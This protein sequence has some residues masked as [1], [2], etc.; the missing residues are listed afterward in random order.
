MS[1]SIIAAIGKNNE[2]GKEN[3][4]L[5]DLPLD[6]KHFKEIT[7]GKTIIMGQKTFES[8]GRP[9]PNRRNIVLTRD[10]NLKI[11]GVEIVYSM[12][13]AFAL[14]GE[15]ETES[16]VIGGGQIYRLFFGKASKLYLTHVE[17][18]FPEADTFFPSI[19]PSEWRVISKEFHPA[20]EKHQ[21][22]FTFKVYERA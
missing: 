3:T 13:E 22:N 12:E 20:D 9:L 14:L 16:F 11:E 1:L 21:Y 17:A 2:L 15:N 7:S 8:I 5:W 4:L 10:E 18:E 19:I 6:L